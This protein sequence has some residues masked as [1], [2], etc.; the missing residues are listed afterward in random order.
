MWRLLKQTLLLLQIF[1]CQNPL[2]NIFVL[3][4]KV[5]GCFIARKTIYDGVIYNYP[6]CAMMIQPV[7]CTEIISA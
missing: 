7:F 1:S 3:T 4:R 2:F 6:V 5:D